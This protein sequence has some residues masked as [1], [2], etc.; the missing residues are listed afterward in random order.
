MKHLFRTQDACDGFGARRRRASGRRALS[1][2]HLGSDEHFEL[3]LA[4][5]ARGVAESTWAIPPEAKLGFYEVHCP[6]RRR[7][8]SPARAA[9][10]RRRAGAERGVRRAPY[11]NTGDWI[12]GSFRVEEFRVPADEGRRCSCRRR[13]RSRRAS[14]PVDL[15][16]QYLAGGGAGGLPVVRARP[17]RARTRPT[18]PEELE[19]FV[20][21]NG[22]GRGRRRAHGAATRTPSD[23]G[24]GAPKIHQR[25]PS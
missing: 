6:E 23:D 11:A 7:R 19:G 12:A 20:F 16:V 10:R 21:A 9:S 14:V 13:R 25:T 5:D 18:L 3:P 2:V 1:I 17:D 22:A 15:A 8:P 4:F 24:D